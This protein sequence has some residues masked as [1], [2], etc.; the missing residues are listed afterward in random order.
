MRSKVVSLSIVVLAMLTACSRHESPTGS[1]GQNVVSG[2]VVMT[3]DVANSS[4][5]GVEVSVAGTGMTAVLAADGAFRFVGVP[6]NAELTFRRADGIDSRVRVFS[7]SGFV[8]VELSNKT[9]TSKGGKRR[10]VSPKDPAPS[11]Q[12]EGVIQTPGTDSLVIL[13]SHKNVVTVAITDATLIRKGD[14]TVKAA[15]L[16]AGDRVHVKATTVNDK[17]TAS[18]VIVQNA[19]DDDDDDKGGKDQQKE[20]EGTIVS[21]SDAQLVVHDSHGHDVTIAL[22]ADTVIRKGN[23]TLKASDLKKNERVH[24]KTTKAADGTLTATQVIVQNENGEGDD[25]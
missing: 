15:D 2:H 19:E 4:P 11:Q 9:A 8:T 18:Q 21:V 6:D 14:Q 10:N 12:I 17:L 3:S 16:K 13:D 23:K 25:D 22:N 5:A 7:S 24:V 1:Y 20:V